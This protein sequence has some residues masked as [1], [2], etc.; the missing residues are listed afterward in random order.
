[1]R[2]N[3]KTTLAGI[4]LSFIPLGTEALNVIGQNQ[5]VDYKNILFGLGFL[6]LGGFA[7][8]YSVTGAAKAAE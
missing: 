5:H 1:M 2:K 6:A 8:D 4:V 7:K 3:W